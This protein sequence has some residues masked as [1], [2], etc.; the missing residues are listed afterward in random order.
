[1]KKI[2]LL[3]VVLIIGITLSCFAGADQ[4]KQEKDER[5]TLTVPRNWYFDADK[6]YEAFMAAHPEVTLVK[7]TGMS[8]SKDEAAFATR[9]AAGDLDDLYGG[10]DEHPDQYGPNGLYIDLKPYLQRDTDLW[11]DSDRFKHWWIYEN[12]NG[13]IYGLPVVGNPMVVVY[14]EDMLDAA[15]LEYPPDEYGSAA[16]DDWTWD[17][18]REYAEVLTD[19]GKGIYGVGIENNIL[20]YETMIATAGGRLINDDAS[21]YTADTPEVRAALDFLTG[22]SLDGLSP[23]PEAA[24][25]SGGI[26]DLFLN[27]QIA[28]IIIGGWNIGGVYH[29]AEIDSGMNIGIAALPYKTNKTNY[30]LAPAQRIGISSTC[31]NPDVAYELLKFLYW[32]TDEII[33]NV[34]EYSPWLSNYPR[35]DLYNRVYD[36]GQIILSNWGKDGRDLRMLLNNHTSQEMLLTRPS[37]FGKFFE[38][39]DNLL[40][41]LAKVMNETQS[42]DEAIVRI[43][44]LNNTV[45][46]R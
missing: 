17:K 33:M 46:S 36:E 30:V 21:R 34:D 28:M 42:F 43:H 19:S 10:G 38:C 32:E 9:V 22:F 4:E 18:F 7:N 8:D 29:A 14:N 15:G 11:Y 12:P 1:M 41:E 45:L 39:R 44:D 13:A 25:K 37:W 23:N 2:L 35:V 20:I 31:E 6:I 40:N 3:S 27:N 26:N 24:K 16:F 5:I